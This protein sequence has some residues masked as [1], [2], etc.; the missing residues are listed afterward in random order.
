ML[1]GMPSLIL[2]SSD[3]VSVSLKSERLRI[4]SLDRHSGENVSRDVPLFDLDRVVLLGT[5]PVTTPVFAALLDRGIPCF[6]ATARNRWRGSLLPDRNRNA[7]RR[8]RQYEQGTD[9][10]FGLRVAR[11]LVF[12]KI[13]NSRRVLQRLAAN[14]GRTDDPDHRNTMVALASYMGE[15]MHA[16]S[17]DVVRG[18]EGI[19]AAIYFRDLGLSVPEELPFRTRSRR[20]PRDPA[21][22]LL[23]FGYT[24]L[25][26]EMECAIRTHGLDAAIGHLHEDTANSPSL[27]LDLMEPLRAP[28]VDLLV[29]NIVNHTMVKAGEHFEVSAEDGGTYLNEEGRRS[30]FMMYENA[31]ERRFSVAKGAPQ[32][33]LRRVLDSQIATY[34]KMLEQDKDED[35]F[36]LP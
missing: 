31:M 20:P 18:V 11:R 9:P 8:V 35:F 26:G 36:F 15:A 10:A 14:R 32:T 24:M 5:P 13:R 21:N 29:L 30:F 1:R 22:A 34:L 12:A 7:A 23:S 16:P 33:T 27:A 19:A 3:L 2:S 28:V 6:F 25:L 4:V 17:V